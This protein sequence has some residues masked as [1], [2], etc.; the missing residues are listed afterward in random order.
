MTGTNDGPLMLDR[1]REARPGIREVGLRDSVALGRSPSAR[2]PHL[3]EN[4]TSDAGD[5]ERGGDHEDDGIE[6]VMAGRGSL[7]DGD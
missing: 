1:S 3:I 5:G 7:P 2:A 4:E 6:H